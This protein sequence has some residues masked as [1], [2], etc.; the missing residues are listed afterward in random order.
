MGGGIRLWASPHMGH[1]PACDPPPAAHLEGNT[2]HGQVAAVLEQSEVLGHQSS[3][4]H[5][6]LGGLCV[7]AQLRVLPRHVLQPRQA[8]VWGALVAPGNPGSQGRSRE[9]DGVSPCSQCLR[10]TY[11]PCTRYRPICP[12]DWP[13]SLPVPCS[14]VHPLTCLLTCPFLTCALTWPLTP[15]VCG[16]AWLMAMPR[17]PHLYMRSTSISGSS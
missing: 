12:T 11:P 16:W 13:V 9:E 7:V 8:Q 1:P 2:A 4:V 3:R 6:A 14:P 5:H 17:P 10:L 15:P